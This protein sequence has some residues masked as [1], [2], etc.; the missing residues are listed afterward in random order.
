MTKAIAEYTK[1]VAVPKKERHQAS[2]AESARVY[3]HVYWRVE[4]V[5]AKCLYSYFVTTEQQMYR[6]GQI[7]VDCFV[8]VITQLV[9]YISAVHSLH[10]S[11]IL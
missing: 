6:R 2:S 5:I 11:I 3:E 7:A 4:S 10:F 8:L 1:T 9:N